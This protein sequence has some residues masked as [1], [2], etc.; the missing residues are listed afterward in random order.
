MTYSYPNYTLRVL[1]AAMFILLV[2][3]NAKAQTATELVF[4]NPS[5]ISG[6]DGKDG[7][8]YRFP[9][10]QTGIDALVKI[11]SRSSTLVKLV[12]IDLTNTGWDK[13]FQPQVSYNDGKTKTAGD[14]WMQFQVSFVQAGTTTATTV[15]SFNVTGLDIDGD[16]NRLNEYLSFYNQSAYTLEQNTQLTVTSLLDDLLGL[17][18]FSNGKK[19]SGTTTDHSGIDTSAT[20]LMVTNTY[21]N[22][23]S[24][25]V[26]TGAKATGS[27]DN[28][29]RQYSMYFK[30]FTYQAANVSSLP[31]K[32]INWNATYNNNI[33]S[34]KWA[35]TQEINASHFIIERSTD[36]FDYT[37]AAMIFATGNSEILLNYSFNDKIPAGN[38]G[39]LY[40]R[41]RSVDMDGK[42]T[43]SDTRIIRLGT[44]TANAVKI[45][46]YPN[47]VQSEL[48]ITVPASWQDKSVV[49]QLVSTNGQTIKTIATGHAGQTEV[50]SMNQVPVGMY[51]V[52]VSCGNETGVQAVVKQ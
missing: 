30:S 47:P 33:V 39:V 19:F 3:A 21:N 20:S 4:K 27:S 49:Y 5:L 23:N 29:S 11:T 42:S 41:L 34:L 43:V 18:T 25:T 40:Y 8:I 15:N 2:S 24:F 32:L 26:R 35:T 45:A 44:A 22:T 52:R 38:S 31:V 51:I 10:V 9:S 50:I 1:F 14:W 6:T 48:R 46:T 16:G 37:D 12:S 13:A 7:A 17:L 28:T 36:G